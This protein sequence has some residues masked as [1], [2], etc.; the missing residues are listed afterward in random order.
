MLKHIR[1]LTDLVR[2]LRRARRNMI[3]AWPNSYY[4]RLFIEVECPGRMMY[5]L[6]D[7]EDIQHVMVTNFK[8]YR[9]SPTTNQVL[10]PLLRNSMFITEGENWSRSR[11]AMTPAFHKSLLEKYAHIMVQCTEDLLETWEPHSEGGEVD[12]TREMTVVTADVVSRAMF[13]FLL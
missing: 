4:R 10:K 2:Y 13:H 11:K 3:E 6:N 8:N 9:K 1:N 7:P 12:L 5:V